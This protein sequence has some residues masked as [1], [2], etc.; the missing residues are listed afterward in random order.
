MCLFIFY[1]FNSPLCQQLF[2]LSYLFSVIAKL[3]IISIFFG[4]FILIELDMIWIRITILN[5]FLRS[6]FKIVWFIHSFYHVLYSLSKILFLKTTFLTLIR[7]HF[8][9]LFNLHLYLHRNLGF[10]CFKL[11][12]FIL[13]LTFAII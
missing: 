2:F 11:A 6:Y 10:F 13:L 7:I 8:Y 12:L 9:N 5:I 3:T 4:V 1:F